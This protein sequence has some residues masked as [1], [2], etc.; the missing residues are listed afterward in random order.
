MYG[1]LAF[2]NVLSDIGRPQ[3]SLA[4]LR[5]FFRPRATESA[6]KFLFHHCIFFFLQLPHNLKMASL[7]IGQTALRASV[8]APAF[9]AKSAAFN[10]LRCYSSKTQVHSKSFTM[11]HTSTLLTILLSRL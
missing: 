8:R 11:R 9:G 7:R 1:N 3:H 10:G 5:A 6:L 4:G 2:N